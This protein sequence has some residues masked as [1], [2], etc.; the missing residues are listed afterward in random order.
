MKVLVVVGSSRTH[1]VSAQV[2]SLIRHHFAE[3]AE[4]EPLWLRDYQIDYCDADNACFDTDC[5]LPDDVREIVCAMESADAIIYLP[6]MHAYGT[7]SRFQAFLER[8]GFGF[9]RHRGRPL[10][11]K[12]AA[13]VVVGRRYGHTSVF[14]QVVLNI[15]LNQ[16]VLVG[17]GFPPTFQSHLIQD[18]EAESA[19]RDTVDRLLEHYHKLHGPNNARMQRVRLFQQI[20]HQTG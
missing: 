11:D 16:M 15:L 19:L 1:G 7:N 3:R 13:V 10:K 4:V 2:V 12:L 14:N 8:V 20:E 6:V 9:M 5:A 18:H 17:S